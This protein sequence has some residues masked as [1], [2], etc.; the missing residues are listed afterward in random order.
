MRDRLF[1]PR[2]GEVLL[3]ADTRMAVDEGSG[4][5]AGLIFEPGRRMRLKGFTEPVVVHRLLWQELPAPQL[6]GS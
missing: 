3:S 6:S 5:E 1:P 2:A 4:R